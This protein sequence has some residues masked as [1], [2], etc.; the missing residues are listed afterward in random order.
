M[1]AP[2]HNDLLEPFPARLRTVRDWYEH[3]EQ[4]GITAMYF[5]PVFESE[6]H[7]YDTTDYFQID[8]RLGD[9]TLLRNIV[10]ELHAR[11][12][13][14]ILDG[15]FNHTGREFFAF[16]DLQQKGRESQYAN[17]YHVRW[18]GDS[19]YRDGFAYESWEGHNLCPS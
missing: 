6:S 14:V 8:R 11:G 15:V 18:E 5:G 10:S 9:V 13:R 19:Q 16:K 12:I 7:G 3:F 2:Y 17:W 1:G 4:L